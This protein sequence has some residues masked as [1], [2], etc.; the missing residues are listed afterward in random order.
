ML[1]QGVI[2]ESGSPGALQASNNPV[3]RQFMS[4]QLEGPID[5]Y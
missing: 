1:H 3:V 5:V 4:G 2:V